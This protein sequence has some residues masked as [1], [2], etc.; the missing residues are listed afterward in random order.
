MSGG[1]DDAGLLA[2]GDREPVGEVEGL[3]FGQVGFDLRPH[4]CLPRVGQE[5]LDDRPPL[6]RLLD[7]EEGLPRHETVLDGLRPGLAALALPDDHP[8]PVV[9]EVQGLARSLHP[10]AENG[11]RLVLQDLLRPAQ[12]KFLG[13]HDLFPNI[14]EFDLCHFNLLF[15]MKRSRKPRPVMMR[16][17]STSVKLPIPQRPSSVGRR[18]SRF[19]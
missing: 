3:A 2:V 5:V 17:P 19:P 6:G 8:D 4:L 18:L 7:G 14:A 15:C 12:G 9:A 13:G 10:V 1:R 16:G 11:H